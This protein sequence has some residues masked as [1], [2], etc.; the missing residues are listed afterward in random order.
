MGKEAKE[1]GSASVGYLK[2]KSAPSRKKYS[3]FKNK[4]N[5]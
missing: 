3:D 1:L 5:K 4:Y 2:E